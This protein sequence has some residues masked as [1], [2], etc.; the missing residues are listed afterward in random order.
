VSTQAVGDLDARAQT[1]SRELLNLTTLPTHST[2]GLLTRLHGARCLDA[3][4][5]LRARCAA[6]AR[7]LRVA[8][9][10]A[11]AAADAA[12]ATAASPSSATTPSSA[13]F[14]AA[15]AD[16]LEWTL[17]APAREPPTGGAA[18]GAAA[19]AAGGGVPLVDAAHGAGPAAQC[20]QQRRGNGGGAGGAGAGAGPGAGLEV[21][22]VPRAVLRRRLHRLRRR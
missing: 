5:R 16:A 1:F 19:G 8:C 12:V 3:G 10:A 17:A 7:A 2:A 4:P 13:T 22:T 15:L 9:A 11:G 14:F 21:E 18:A 20:G 6:A